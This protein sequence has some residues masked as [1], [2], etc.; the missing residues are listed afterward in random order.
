M[1]ILSDDEFFEGMLGGFS[2]L[3]A[4]YFFQR[5]ERHKGN[6]IVILIVS[7]ACFWYI[8]KS[9]MNLYKHYKKE[10]KIPNK[11]LSIPG[12][13]SRFFVILTILAMIY[14]FL[15][16]GKKIPYKKIYRFSVRDL[17]LLLFVFTVGFF[18]YP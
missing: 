12:K 7:W 16:R 10:H 6:L 9:G 4:N 3:V 11:S 18:L 13:D 17:G 8:R 5:Q 15:R 1:K 2:F 14:F